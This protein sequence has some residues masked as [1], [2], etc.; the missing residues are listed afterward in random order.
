MTARLLRFESFEGDSQTDTLVE[1]PMK[2][3]IRAVTRKRGGGP[4]DRVGDRVA[5]R[6]EIQ[7]VLGAGS[8]GAVFEA[9]DMKLGVNVAIK[10]LHEHLRTSDGHVARFAREVRATS[11]IAHPSVVRVL[12]AGEDSDGS[13][14]LVMELLEGELLL[15]RL[16]RR[17]DAEEVL[18]ISRQLLGALAAA[19]AQGIIHRDIKPENL[20]VTRAESGAV[21]LKVLDFGIAKLVRP[22][23]SL[24]FQTLDGLILGTPAYM[25]PEVCRGLPV[26]EAADLWAASAVIFEAFTGAPPF[27]DTH[28]GKLLIKIVRTR[29]P[30]LRTLRPDLPA[31]VIAAIDRGLDPEPSERWQS[32]AALAAAL[33]S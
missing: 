26:T 6:Y 4:E 31:H 30:S 15:R 17:I 28:V 19:H 12:D 7:H 20:F 8:A 1:P 33:E 27:E 5:G 18:E 23:K 16:S 25:S 24:S 29:A 22:H 9:R 11:A 13:L 2:S 10:V 32:A 3:E 14:F 21:L